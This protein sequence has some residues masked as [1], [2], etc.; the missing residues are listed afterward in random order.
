MNETRTN[1]LIDRIA[2]QEADQTSFREFET[3]ARDQPELWERLA[4]SLR[5]ELDLRS[6]MHAS[7]HG[8]RADAEI[9][10][11]IDGSALRSRN[12]K[13]Q[14]QFRMWSGWAAAAVIVLTWATLTMS[15]GSGE[16]EHNAAPT[17]MRLIS[18]TADDAFEQY[19]EIGH[20]EGRVIGELP[21]RMIE[22][23][24][25]DDGS[26]VVYYVRQL[27][28]RERIDQMYQYMPDELG[29]PL[30]VPIHF[31]PASLTESSL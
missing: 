21:A 11:A 8:V 13:P 4:R 9:R 24:S 29:R 18:L 23:E 17:G 30:P 3:A 14:F 19:L 12:R 10:A 2:A 5:D 27:L 22:F 20:N 28:E 31:K 26:V 25:G 16:P 6:A 7:E 15:T 1:T